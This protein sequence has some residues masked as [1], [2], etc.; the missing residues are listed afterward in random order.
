VAHPRLRFTDCICLSSP[1][2]STER[3]PMIWSSPLTRTHLQSNLIY[4]ARYSECT[5]WTLQPPSNFFS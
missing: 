5:Q 4:L 1:L 3:N 2:I